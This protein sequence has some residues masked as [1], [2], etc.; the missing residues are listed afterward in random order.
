MT[1]DS[2]QETKVYSKDADKVFLFCRSAI[3]D[4]GAEIESYD[5]QLGLIHANY[6]LRIGVAFSG[7]IH[8]Y[9]VVTPLQN[10]QAQITIESYAVY[11]SS[12]RSSP[13]GKPKEVI[14]RILSR[15]GDAVHQAERQEQLQ[16]VDGSAK[17]QTTFPKISTGAV[18]LEERTFCPK[19]RAAVSVRAIKC[20][21]CDTPLSK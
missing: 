12:S 9:V 8:I 4:V 7:N 6:Y 18:P 10:N 15:V 11:S 20:Q 2:Y 16:G 14:Y 5:E 3:R 21:W 1:T 13:L 17:L 19:C